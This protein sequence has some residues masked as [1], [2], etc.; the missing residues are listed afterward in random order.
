MV[1]IF[2]GN[3]QKSLIG[4]K[5]LHQEVGLSLIVTIPD[6]IIKK[7]VTIES[8]L[9]TFAIAQKIPYICVNKLDEHTINHIEDKNP[10]FFVVED[11]GLILP[12][13][14][15]AIPKYA[16]INVHHS[17][18][19]KYRGPAPAPYAILAGEQ[20]SGVSIIH[21]TNQVDAGD[22]YDQE[23]YI[24]SADETTDSLLSKLN[25][26]GGALAVQVIKDIHAGKAVKKPQD[27]SKVS[28]T[29]YM[30]KS[31][32]YIDLDNPPTKTQIDR[33]IRAY[34][35]WPNVWSFIKI[36]NK[37]I[38]IKFLPNQKIQVEG[39]SP[40]TVKEFL[41]GYPDLKYI[42]DKVY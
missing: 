31:D 23:S 41:N 38:R 35:P 13:K 26:L 3:T 16:P 25:E 36:K 12:Q 7:N 18:L 27:S 14:L 24:L 34:Y 20:K 32:G 6:R 1:I 39:K 29:H 28:F 19:P 37:D 22:I 10:D 21:M 8:P 5:I 11:Y 40:L 17:L 30:K 42:V 9:K 33:M 4:A 15:L 2:F